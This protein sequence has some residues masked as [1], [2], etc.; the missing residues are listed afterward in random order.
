MGNSSSP[1]EDGDREEAEQALEKIQELFGQE[2]E[3]S[4]E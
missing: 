3:L 1:D 2:W 4:E